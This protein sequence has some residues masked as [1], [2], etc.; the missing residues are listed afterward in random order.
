MSMEQITLE[1]PPETPLE[2]VALPHTREHVR[3]VGIDWQVIILFALAWEVVYQLSKAHLAH[4]YPEWPKVGKL[5]GSYAAAFLNACV[6]SALGC[7]IVMGLFDADS[8][9]RAL[10]LKAAPY[11]AITPVVFLA[12][13]SFLGWLMMDLAHVVLLYPTLG[14]VDILLHHSGFIFLTCLGY[15]YRVLPFTVGWLLLC[16]VSTIGLNLRWFLIN[17]GRGESSAL[18]STNAFFAAT[19]FIF[20]VVVQWTGIA[21]LLQHSRPLLLERRAPNWAVDTICVSVVASAVL[22]LYWLVKI[23]QMAR[24]PAGK[25]CRKTDE[26]D[27][28]SSSLVREC[29]RDARISRESSAD[30]LSELGVSPT[31]ASSEVLINV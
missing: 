9:G 13:R 24:R 27:A 12:E 26:S 1:A 15:G 30:G 17:T 5:G 3:W 28:F 20:R 25:E 16:E 23:V 2:W 6:C 7:L 29:K 18:R 31:P 8:R 22:N 10:M 19:F 14:G 4:R 21:D 11:D